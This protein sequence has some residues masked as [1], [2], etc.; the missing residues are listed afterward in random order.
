MSE[1]IRNVMAMTGNAEATRLASERGLKIMNVTWE[2]VGRYKNSAVGPN[3]TD[4]TIQVEDGNSSMCM[5]VIRNPNFA[6]KSGDVNPSKF[7]L[8]VGNEKDKTLTKVTL[9]EFLQDITKYISF[10]NNGTIK[11]SLFEDRDTYVLT[12]AQACFLPVPAT[13]LGKF[14][15]VAFNY[16]SRKGDP[17][18][19]AI[20]AT[21][22]GTSVTVIDN[23]RDKANGAWGQKLYF[24][25]NG[26]KCS[27]TA[28]RLKE[29]QAREEKEI[30][31]VKTQKGADMVL[32]IQVPLK[33][34]EQDISRGATFGAAFA[35]ASMDSMV[36]CSTKGINHEVS[37]RG[38]LRSRGLAPDV[39]RAVIGHG[40]AEGEFVELDGLTIERDTNFPVRVTVQFYKATSNGAVNA[41]IIKELADDIDRV[42]A[43]AEFVGSLVVG[44]ETTRVTEHADKQRTEPPQWWPQFWAKHAKE[45]GTATIPATQEKLTEMF[46]DKW[47]GWS[48][49]EAERV[50]LSGRLNP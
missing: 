31:G 10:P 6:D 2:D 36:Q 11:G 5:P 41:E 23:Q 43:D 7:V 26:E 47:R 34:K 50:R 38:M 39:D 45:N 49:E 24:N 17:A 19:L 21:R 29:V 22:E 12:S 16:Q 14:T 25:K 28:E 20:L 40:A 9:K 4:M 13:E 32:L 35:G 3:I 27:I 18:V 48:P 30:G 37:G 1:C 44:G 42:Y 15:P 46:G 33:Q 8:L